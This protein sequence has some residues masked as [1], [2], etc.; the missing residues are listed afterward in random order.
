MR[1]KVLYEN[2]NLTAHSVQTLD[3]LTGIAKNGLN[4]LSSVEPAD[5]KIYATGLIRIIFNTTPVGQQV[6]RSFAPD[7]PFTQTHKRIDPSTIIRIEVDIEDLMDP[8][9]S[10]EAAADEFEKLCSQY[11]DK[12][13]PYTHRCW[14]KWER[15]DEFRER[16]TAGKA[17]DAINWR[18]QIKQALQ[19]TVAANVPIVQQPKFKEEK[20][21]N[22]STW[23]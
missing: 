16:L 10:E 22:P 8:P 18:Q 11:P 21:G 9:P 14:D 1:L 3:E 7:M 4:E 2:A 17:I 20:I 23:G 12:K 19:G 6:S 5:A 13:I 15:W